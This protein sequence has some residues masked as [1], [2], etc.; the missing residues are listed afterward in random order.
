MY[1]RLKKIW[2]F[3]LQRGRRRSDVIFIW[4]LNFVELQ[5]TERGCEK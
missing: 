3:E 2:K 4:M 5:G 1:D